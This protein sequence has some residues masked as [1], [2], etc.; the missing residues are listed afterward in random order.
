VPRDALG[1]IDPATLGEEAG[2]YDS[3]SSVNDWAEDV[4]ALTASARAQDSVRI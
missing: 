4:P 3:K 1:S 2:A